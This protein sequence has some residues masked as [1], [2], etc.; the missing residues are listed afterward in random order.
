M[1]Q[2][3]NKKGPVPP[4][5]KFQD[6]LERSVGYRAYAKVLI[7]KVFSKSFWINLSFSLN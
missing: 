5:S 6:K 4:T 3:S 1:K 7:L 2:N